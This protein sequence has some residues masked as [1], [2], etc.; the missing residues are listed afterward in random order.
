LVWILLA[1]HLPGCTGSTDPGI[2]PPPT[3]GF[4]PRDRDLDL[5]LN[6][7]LAFRAT[8]TAGSLT[9]NWYLDGQMVGQGREYNFNPAGAGRHELRVDASSGAVRDTCHWVISVA[10]VHIDFYPRD[11]EQILMLNKARKFN[12]YVMPADSIAVSWR[13]DGQIVGE[14]PEFTY[15]ATAPGPCSLEAVAF[16]GT[17]RDTNSWT[18]DV[19]ED[20]ALTPPEVSGVATR[21]GPNVADVIVSWNGVTGDLAYPLV[22]YIV[23]VDFDEPVTE[24]NWDR[25]D[26]LGRYAADPGQGQ[27]SEIYTEADHGMRQGERCWFA[28]RVVNDQGRLSP[29]NTSVPFDVTRAWYLGGRVLDDAGVPVPEVSLETSGPVL[30]AVSDGDGNFLFDQPFH[31][32]DL[33]RIEALSSALYPFETDP[34]TGDDDTTRVDLTLIN[35]YPLANPACWNGEFL[36]FLQDV[37]RN[38]PVAGDPDASRLY[39][40]EEYPVTVFIPPAVNRAGV[41]MEAAS[42]AGMEL[43]NETMRSEAASRGRTETDYFVRTTDEATADIVFLFE[44]SS[45]NYGRASLL[46]PHGPDYEFGETVPE[47]MQ[48]WINTTAALDLFTEVQ[49]VALHELGHTLGIYQHADCVGVDYLMMTAGGAGAMNRSEPIHRDE[50]RAVRA[51]RNL[52]QGMNLGVSPPYGME[53]GAALFR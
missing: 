38:P 42:L 50:I 16:S 1:L 51:I 25:A 40:W 29:L 46:L 3:I 20:P 18:I 47:K 21:I 43:W 15:V 4:F 36:E 9:A 33:V 28:V 44:Y 13:L 7:V 34:I 22:E 23:A 24:D 41:N 48:V 52:P 30:S 49:G 5:R 8:A 27:Y 39:K 26:I 10:S 31:N 37:T 17:V 53:I 6:R 14:D 19:L 11:P 45:V 32:I 12:A 35:R 2:E